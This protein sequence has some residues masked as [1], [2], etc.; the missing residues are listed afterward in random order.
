MTGFIDLEEVKIRFNEYD[1]D[2]NG[3]ITLDEFITCYLQ[4]ENYCK[5]KIA[6]AKRVADEARIQKESFE[7]KLREAKVER[8]M[9][10]GN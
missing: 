3:V 2:H 6:N 1:L 8:I 10:I 7:V 4:D 5:E 9:M